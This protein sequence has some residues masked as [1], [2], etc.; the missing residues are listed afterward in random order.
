MFLSDLAKPIQAFLDA[1]RT[2]D[3]EALLATFTEDAVLS[4]MGKDHRGAQIPA[5]N[6]ALY[7]G[8][9]VRVHPLHVEAR[10]GRRL[11]AGHQ[12]GK[13]IVTA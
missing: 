12:V 1:T 7:L 2:R 4:D 6:E 11:R 9:N 8:S 10:E 3:T 5:W 13:L